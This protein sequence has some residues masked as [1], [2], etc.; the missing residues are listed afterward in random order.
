M[1]SLFISLDVA[2]SVGADGRRKHTS[3][4]VWL[5]IAAHVPAIHRAGHRFAASAWLVWR[6]HRNNDHF[7]RFDLICKFSLKNVL[8]QLRNVGIVG[9]R[10]QRAFAANDAARVSEDV[11]DDGDWQLHDGARTELGPPRSRQNTR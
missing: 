2:G 5:S 4:I 7:V 10:V 8:F 11:H 1:S 6:G 3:I 9:R